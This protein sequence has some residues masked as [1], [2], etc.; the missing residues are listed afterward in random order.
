[1]NKTNNDKK[2]TD[3]YIFLVQRFVLAVIFIYICEQFVGIFYQRVFLWIVRTVLEAD[4]ITYKGSTLVG[5]ARL[6]IVTLWNIISPVIPTPLLKLI[7]GIHIPGLSANLQAPAFISSYGTTMVR[8]Y[9][10][11]LI[12]I[13]IIQLLISLLPYA[14]A[15]G[16]YISTIAKKIQEI[17]EDDYRQK[18]AY[19]KQRNLMFSDIVH[20]IKTPITTI[21]GYTRALLDGMVTDPEKQQEYLTAINGKSMRIS[22]LIST[23]FEYVKLDSAGFTLHQETCDLAELVRECVILH[24]MDFEEK[25]LIMDFDIPEEENLAYVDKMQMSR[26]VTNLLTNTVRYL[27]SGDQVIVSMKTVKEN[28]QDMYLISVADNG[29]EIVEDLV[30]NIFDP[31]TRA[32]KARETKGGSGLG[33]SIAHKVAV[34]H[35]GDLRLNQPC[36]NNM[37]K[38]FEIYVPTT[39]PENK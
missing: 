13:I 12:A 37:T 21:N 6:F 16:W 33:L 15:C 9:Y 5:F 29:I 28:G 2:I 25:G 8:L 23:L 36:G 22:E 34:M 32:D 10:L 1:M 35:G 38:A 30:N 24:F 17:R 3:L 4:T 14:I 11:T 20:D 19:D 26:V 31:F 39:I 27:Q 18:A 7:N